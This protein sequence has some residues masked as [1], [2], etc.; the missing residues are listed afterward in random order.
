MIK[1]L[2]QTMRPRQWTKN[3]FVFFA[4]VFDHQLFIVDSLLRTIAVF[5]LFSLISS[6]VYIVN[7]IAD[8]K[9]NEISPDE[10][11]AAFKAEYLERDT[12]Y[13]LVE[14]STDSREGRKV[15]CCASMI[16]DGQA[17]EHARTGNGPIDLGP[18][19]GTV[20]EVGGLFPWGATLAVSG[21]VTLV[22]DY[23]A[24]IVNPGGGGTTPEPAS[25]LLAAVGLAAALR[26]GRSTRRK[27]AL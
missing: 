5:F 16:I 17:R 18:L 19:A 10:V 9:G 24:R 27:Q 22:Y 13:K 2:I 6:A 15:A 8:V 12:P 21:S 3:G 11:F 1:A 14:F 7:D 23:S 26:A 4:L 20:S 25:A